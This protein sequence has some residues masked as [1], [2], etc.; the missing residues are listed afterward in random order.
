LSHTLGDLGGDVRIPPIARS[1][2]RS[3]LYIRR[4]WFCWLVTL[5]LWVHLQSWHS[6]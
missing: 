3:R 2:T 6:V 4:N 1:E 5:C